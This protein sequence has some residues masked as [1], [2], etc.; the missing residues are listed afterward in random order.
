M[1][2]KLQSV[3]K[4]QQV[5][6]SL[7][8]GVLV[9]DSSH[10]VTFVNDPLRRMVPLRSMAVQGK[11]VW[12][13]IAD[14][15]IATLIQETLESESKMVH[16]EI[17]L[18]V[19]GNTKTLSIDITPLIEA[20]AIIGSVITCTD[21]TEKKVQEVRLKRA[22][23][24]ASLTHMVAG[25]AHEIKNPLG[26]MAIYVQLM[27]RE[28][29]KKGA[30]SENPGADYIEVLEDE[31]ER[32]NK[33]VVDFL[34]AVRPI[35]LETELVDPVSVID[36][37]M[38][39]LQPE[40]EKKSIRVRKQY[41]RH[42]PRIELDIRLF[43]QVLFNLLQNS[44]AAIDGAGVIT[45][46]TFVAHGAYHIT[47]SDTGCGI[48]KEV[49]GKIFEP[50]YTTRETGTGLGLTMVYKIIQEHGGN[51]EARSQGIGT[52]MDC[53]FPIPLGELSLLERFYEGSTAEPSARTIG[54]KIASSRRHD[55]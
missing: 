18:G 32:L 7:L 30:L 55:L 40:F 27:K 42:L 37:V 25:V 13:V 52:T 47:V 15:D 11:V 4:L 17:T 9:V 35:S 8:Q 41:G 1:A 19:R 28:I 39:F 49:L 26:A 23:S 29:E 12:Q 3:Q 2:Q 16:H 46:K 44:V 6:D 45:V 24:L 5:M 43:K 51:I 22:E 38:L 21:I 36:E 33:T 53:S 31:L 20:K 14:S 54:G 50:Y 34:F 48:D 10:C